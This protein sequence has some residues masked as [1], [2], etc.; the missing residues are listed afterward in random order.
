[1]TIRDIHNN[2]SLWKITWAE[3]KQQLKDLGYIGI[4]DSR[5]KIIY[6][7]DYEIQTYMHAMFLTDYELFI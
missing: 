4:V 6:G 1:M 2:C 5:K 7:L 3:A